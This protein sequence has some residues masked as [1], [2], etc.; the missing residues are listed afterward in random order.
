MGFAPIGQREAII[1]RKFP[2]TQ[3]AGG[4][5]TPRDA[6]HLVFQP[7][8]GADSSSILATKSN[9]LIGPSIEIKDLELL[10]NPYEA[11]FETPQDV[12]ENASAG[13][14]AYNIQHYGP[15]LT[16]I[17]LRLQT[18]NLLPYRNLD[19][20]QSPPRQPHTGEKEDLDTLG[21]LQGVHPQ[22]YTGLLLASP[23][24]QN[25]LRFYTLYNEF[26][27]VNEVLLMT[28]MRGIFRGY[29]TNWT[30]TIQAEKPWN[31]MYGA[32]FVVLQG[33]AS[34]YRSDAS[35]DST[36]VSNITMV[37][38]VDPL[39]LPLHSPTKLFFLPGNDPV[40]FPSPFNLLE[41]SS[42]VGPNRNATAP[43][44]ESLQFTDATDFS[45]PGVY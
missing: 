4:N 27:A 14:A 19:S 34:W 11:T 2:K 38:G 12:V 36:L 29:L 43:V 15:G 35:A 37:D 9:L 22:A 42:T 8:N 3:L 7:I 26:D 41:Q 5:L 31:W 10:T 39:Y 16:R 6:S 18:G 21:Y 17:Q 44:G 32:D 33:L 25:F 30:F 13:R 28:F 20:L 24:F 23:R 1:F 45:V 40:P